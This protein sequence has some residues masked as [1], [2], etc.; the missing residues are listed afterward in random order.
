[1]VIA[2]EDS[3]FY[4]GSDLGNPLPVHT[5]AQPWMDQRQ[6]LAVTLPPLAVIVLEY[7][8]E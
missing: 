6:S 5:D 7:V 3:R 2:A 1:M 8:P 4:G